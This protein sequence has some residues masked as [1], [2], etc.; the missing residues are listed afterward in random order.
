M[1][2]KIKKKKIKVERVEKGNEQDGHEEKITRSRWGSGRVEKNE[3][4]VLKL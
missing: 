4:A 2:R 1:T 3:R